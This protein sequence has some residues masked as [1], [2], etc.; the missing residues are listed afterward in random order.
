MT[1]EYRQ[2]SGQRRDISSKDIPGGGLPEM[3]T[4]LYL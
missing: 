4:G 2:Q 3:D 1:E